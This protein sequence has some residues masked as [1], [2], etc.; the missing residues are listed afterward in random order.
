VRFYKQD[1]RIHVQTQT[2]PWNSI[3]GIRGEVT[4][5]RQPALGFI[6]DSDAFQFH[7]RGNSLDIPVAWFSCHPNQYAEISTLFDPVGPSHIAF[8]Q[9]HGS[10]SASCMM[11]SARWNCTPMVKS[12]RGATVRMVR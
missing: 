11:V 7:V 6:I 8:R 3:V 9:G 2:I 5:R 12:S 1:G 4:L 10:R